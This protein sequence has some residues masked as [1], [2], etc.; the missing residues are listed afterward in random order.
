[1][2]DFA[3]WVLPLA[4]CFVYAGI[5]GYL[6]IH[7]L[8]RKVIFV[9]LA[10]A[11]I[12]A[13]G[14]TYALVLGFDP[15][16]PED[17]TAVFLF[18]LGFTILGAA[19]FAFTRMRHEKVPQE[20]FIGIVYASAAAIAILV[21]AKSPHG[22]EQ[23]RYMLAGNILLVTENK[24]VG[25]AVLYAFVGLF[26][27]I[28]RRRFFQITFDPE[29]AIAEGRR[30]RLWDFLFYASFGV[31]ITSSVAVAGVLLVFAYLVVPASIAV[32]FTQSVRTR[33]IVGW[34]VGVAV[35]ILGMTLSYYG[36]LPTGPA[37]VGCFAVAL[38]LAGVG[39]YL[40][41]AP[42]I[43]R[44]ILKL[45]AALSVTVILVWGSTFL[46]RTH[47]EHGHEENRFEELARILREG[48]ENQQIDAIHHLEETKDRHAVEE[49][50]K[51]LGVTKSDRLK[52]HL[53][54]GLAK[55]GDASA[56]PALIASAESGDAALK[57]TIAEAILALRSPEGFRLLIDVLV[58]D[59]PVVS[60][61]KAVEVLAKVGG[62]VK[63]PAALESW[64]ESR[65]RHLR[66]RETTKR[67]E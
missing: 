63:D 39:H 23:L 52:E 17:A 43:G 18:S 33:I 57:V 46:A 10:M 13:L 1:M 64:W 9:D 12:A 2:H 51:L 50:V 55:L 4:I 22:G 34:M 61:A 11:Q 47:G 15:A 16:R 7:V 24:V 30:V 29:A 3:W 66:W 8:T 56:V 38:A 42:H 32:L 27:W 37:V 35:S 5:H 67:F 25:T 45:T 31:V 6:G 19:V 28:F 40:R 21:L 36:D 14:A 58:G 59:A 62:P 44:S 20:A 26:H 48:E 54:H 65:G 53:A 41:H 49:F 60:R